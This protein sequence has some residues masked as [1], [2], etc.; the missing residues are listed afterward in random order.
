[1]RE[2]VLVE[3]I[4]NCLRA[5]AEEGQVRRLADEFVPIHA[6]VSARLLRCVELIREGKDTV[7]MQEAQVAPPLMDVLDALSFAKIK[8]W[9]DR[10]VQ[11]GYTRPVSF[12][13]KL[14]SMMGELYAKPIDGSDPLY[15]DLAHAMR[16]KNMDE[17]LVLLRLICRK[18]PSDSNAFSQLKRTESGIMERK[19]KELFSL[20]E[21]QNEDGFKPQIIAFRQE[22]WSIQPQGDL[23]NRIVEYEEKLRFQQVVDRTKGIID[24]LILIRRNGD[25]VRAEGLIG[26][27]DDLRSKDSFDLRDRA[28]NNPERSYEEILDLCRKWIGKEK[29]D[30]RLKEE[31]KGRESSLKLLVRS[32][33]DKEIGRRRKTDD[34][35]E[36]LAALTSMGRDLQ[37]AEQSLEEDDLKNFTRCLNNLKAEIA[38]RQKAFRILIAFGCVFAISL[39]G[40]TFYVISEKLS[41]EG[42]WETLS[43]GIAKNINVDDLE[44]FINLFEKTYPDRVLEQEFA[45]E[46]KKARAVITNARKVNDEFSQRLQ[47][48]MVDLEDANDLES[49]RGM[50]ERKKLLRE[51]LN[52]L[53]IAHTGMQQDGMKRADFA[54]NAKRDRIQRGIS[55]NLVELLNEA[56]TFSSENLSL[57]QEEKV[58]R[59]NLVKMNRFV[60]DLDA[61][62]A[63]FEGLDGLGFSDGQKQLV[64]DIK[65]IYSNRRGVVEAYDAALAKLEGVGSLDDHLAAITAIVESSFLGG[66]LF[67]EAKALLAVKSM[68]KQMEGRAF[69]EDDYQNWELIGNE[70]SDRYAPEEMVDKESSFLMELYAEK[71]LNKVFRTPL[72]RSSS[73][74]DFVLVSETWMP[75]R[76]VRDRT[77]LD[78]LEPVWTLDIKLIEKSNFRKEKTLEVIS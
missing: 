35:K 37:D 40:F 68:L 71:R 74:E 7:A 72:V 62:E 61:E 36:D 51:N 5:D 48:L 63:K 49:L 18:N 1:M 46:V 24:E 56:D 54:W 55:Q 3:E 70:L 13:S 65:Q 15:R 64:A 4:K 11:L 52:N 42:D 22:P 76:I 34:L 19:V 73:G 6:K 30:L 59:E 43:G 29:E 33:M 38:R 14:V 67:E 78:K 60:N 41:R 75:R 10:I 8:E 47:Q 26:I 28:G 25:W 9:G 12:D 27:V 39:A 58:L 44:T 45:S 66:D 31:S 20:V 16:T 69:L 32:I 77:E 23:W 57:Q 2:R 17:A 53:N 21:Q 50:Q